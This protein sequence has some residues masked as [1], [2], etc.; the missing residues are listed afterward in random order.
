MRT[1][2][3]E[4]WAEWNMRIGFLFGCLTM[5]TL[6]LLGLTWEAFLAVFVIGFASYGITDAI[7]PR[8]RED[9]THAQ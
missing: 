5:G 1:K 7:K 9:N 8:T 4:Q 2:T 3:S 6:G